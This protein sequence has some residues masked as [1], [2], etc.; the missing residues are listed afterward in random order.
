MF[1]TP[2]M[3]LEAPSLIRVRTPAHSPGERSVS[4]A[5]SWDGEASCIWSIRK[6]SII[7]VANTVERF[8][9]HD[10]NYARC[11]RGFEGVKG[12]SPPSS[13]NG[14]HVPHRHIV[15]GGGDVSH[16]VIDKGCTVG[17]FIPIVDVVART[18]WLAW[19]SGIIVGITGPH[20]SRRVLQF[21]GTAMVTRQ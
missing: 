6:A 15:G 3:A 11:N 2:M 14:L 17:G 10:R 4:G 13:G 8:A 19:L 21:L 18:S 16:A 7:R 9:C 12:S 20:V 5:C 1:I